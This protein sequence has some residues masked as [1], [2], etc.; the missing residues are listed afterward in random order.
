MLDRILAFSLSQRAFILGASIFL[1]ICGAWS[2]SQLPIDAF[3]EIA[4]TQVKLILKAP[5]MTPEEVEARIVRPLEQEFLGIPNQTVMRATAKYA[6]TDITI[7]FKDG[8]DV[9][10]AR[11]QVSE[12]LTAVRDT[13]PDTVQG[14][15]APVSTALSE[16]FMF[17]IEG[18]DLTLAERRSLLDWVIRPSLRTLPGVADVNALG[19]RVRSFDIIPDQQAMVAAGVSLDEIYTVVMN[20]NRNDGAGRVTDGE[21]ALV[22]RTL[23]SM[24]NE[25]DI[26]KMVIRENNDG[27]LRLEDVARVKLGSLTR[28]GS[29]TKDGVGEAVEGIVVS[30]KGA[31]ARMVVSG[32]E[33]RLENLKPSLP[34]G[35]TIEVFYNRSDL[36]NKAVGTVTQAL[37]MAS[38]L[39]IALLVLFLGNLRAAIVVTLSL[40]F[41]ALGAFLLMR[42]FGLSANLMSLGGLAIAIGM[43]VDSA[44]VVTENSVERLSENTTQN[45]LHVVFRAASEVALPTAAGTLIICLVFLPLLT[46]EGLEGKLFAPVALAI[47]FALGSALVLAFTLI[48]VLA[49]LLL[50]TGTSRP[51]AIMRLITPAYEHL[52]DWSLRLPIVTY[53]ITAFAIVI[54]VVSYGRLGKTFMPTM[55]EGAV[56]MQLASLPSINLRQSEADDL[57]IGQALMDNVPEVRHVISRVGSDELG[58]DPMPLNESDVFLQLAPREDWRGP[59]TDWLVNEMRAVLDDFIGIETSFTQPIEMRVSELLTGSR[60]DLAVKI[61]GPES[62]QLADLAGQIETVIAGVEGAAD[63]YTTSNDVAEYL[64]IDTDFER[65]GLLGI[66]VISLQRELR[67]RLE[68]VQAGEVIEP[69]RRTPILIRAD[70]TYRSNPHGF[71]DLKFVSS[72][73]KTIR[74]SDVATIER[75]EGL[76][77]VEREDG[78]RYA[79]VE[80]FVQGRDLVGFVTDA[81]RAVE[82]KIDLPSGYRV[83]F[84]GEF[85][86][87]RRAAQRL[88]L[89]IPISLILI[90]VVLFA[91]LRS[92]RQALL[93]LFNIPLALIGGVIALGISGEYLSVPASVGF[94]ALLGIAV[95]NGLVLITYFNDLRNLGHSVDETIRLGAS[96]RLRPVLM[97]ATTAGFGLMPL[98]FAAGPGSEIQKPLAI[99]VIGGLISSTLLTLFLLP[100]LYRKFGVS[101]DKNSTLKEVQW[102]RPYAS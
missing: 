99:V 18:G 23:G 69:S 70:E 94:I 85:Q 90:F 53:G 92:L 50:K 73:S 52:L 77:S 66:D 56:V 31:D 24:K 7:D 51:A 46:L 32:V 8:T 6:I 11:Q 5:G 19:G 96:R 1:A 78:S 47:V 60:G 61:F 43:I 62:A 63:V 16:L 57:R 20:N 28:Y 14:G 84:G 65:A 38:I 39:V 17:T 27:V 101:R 100:I 25:Q 36:I 102:T 54:A 74:L 26:A 80:A 58:L 4:P 21:E 10:W 86:N 75:A 79:V 76:A 55:N 91:T 49:S 97:T 95:L 41:A 42:I 3:P 87:Q 88:A 48:P 9:Y 83:E 35:I 93:I 13:L 34:E 2:A 98:L 72:G 22:V 12:R 64:Q 45:K 67:S 71:D 37:L 59:D 81:Q 15:L 29:V 33:A 40:P 82:Q 30:L 89:M 44:I 68:G